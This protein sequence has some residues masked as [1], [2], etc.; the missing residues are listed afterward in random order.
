MS[1]TNNSDQSTSSENPEKKV[2]MMGKIFNAMRSVVHISRSI[3]HK[4]N[5]LSVPSDLRDVI[6]TEKADAIIW[7]INKALEDGIKEGAV[8]TITSRISML[9]GVL[10]QYKWFRELE[11]TNPDKARKVRMFLIDHGGMAPFL[12]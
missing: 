1:N 7:E 3:R 11:A 8:Y 2:G 12:A 6:D 10:K 9:D 5:E 4:L